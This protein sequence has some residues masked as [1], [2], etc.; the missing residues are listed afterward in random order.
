GGSKFKLHWTTDDGTVLRTTYSFP[1]GGVKDGKITT[2]VDSDT[3]K[4]SPQ[5]FYKSYVILTVDQSQFN[6][7]TNARRTD[8]KNIFRCENRDCKGRCHT[9][10]AMDSFFS[11]PTAHSHA[12]N[13]NRFE[14][15][16]VKS[17]IKHRAAHTD[18]SSSSILHGVLRTMP[19]SAVGDLPSD[20][21]LL[22]TIQRQ[23][24]AVP[25]SPNSY[26]PDVLK[27]TDRGE[28]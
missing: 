21:T 27:K 28:D 19:L 3:V 15:N 1:S 10:L 5:G 20:D 13:P 14:I 8:I 24:E 7:C 12:T 4:L 9:N 25:L 23:R 6:E 16:K 11:Q 22:R 2:R 17:E 18:E 26:L